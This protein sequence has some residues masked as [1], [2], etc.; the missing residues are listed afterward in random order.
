MMRDTKIAFV[1]GATGLLGNNLV[2]MLLAE[3]VQV[4][5]LARSAEKARQQFGDLAG[6]EIVE[7]DMEDVTGFAGA[8]AGCDTLF[9][10]AAYFRDSY[11]GG[12]HWDKLKAI[13]IDATGRL[14]IAAHEAGI[15]QIVHTSSIAVV[16]G[17][18]GQVVNETMKRP[19]SG[20]DDYYRSKILSDQTVMAHLDRH[21]ETFGVFV[22][23]GWMHGP[24]DRGPTA[25]GQ[26]TLDFMRGKLP[27]I[28]PATFAFVDAR[29]VAR[30]EILALR[31]GRRGEHYLAAGRHVAMTDL[32]QLYQRV[33]GVAAPKRRIPAAALWSI[34]GI[35]EAIARLTGRPALLSLAAVRNMRR[36]FEHSR[37][38]PTKA[39]TELGLSFR[40]MEETIADEVAWYR[41]NGMLPSAAT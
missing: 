19:A 27:G 22:M 18:K 16:D 20:A 21:P 9:H 32:M 41:A 3:G 40:P 33:T 5:G 26:F 23:P 31:Q 29:D 15:R 12:S 39:Q 34:A 25:A 24:G 10:T 8:L 11:Y 36:E 37:F 7:G 17:E 28:P 35:Q 38:D 30:A 13:N 6:L 1:T 4:R 2:R 14:L